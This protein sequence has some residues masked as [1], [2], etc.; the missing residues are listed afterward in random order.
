MLRTLP[1]LKISDEFREMIRDR[2]DIVEIIG[3]TVAL[4]Q[5]G[6]DFVGLCP[7]HEERTPS[8]HVVPSKQFFHCFGCKVGGDV[9][10]FVKL[11]DKVDFVDAV[12]ILADD[13]GVPIPEQESQDPKAPKGFS[14]KL[15]HRTLNEVADF[16]HRQLLQNGQADQARK[17]LESRDIPLEWWK[18][19]QLGYAPSGPD[20]LFA[21]A[22]RQKKWSYNLLTHL[23]L[24]GRKSEG[25][26]FYER[27][28]GRLI[29]PIHD[30]PGNVIGFSARRLPPDTFG[31]KYIN[32]RETDLFHKGRILYNLHRAKEE[33]AKSGYV[34]VCEGQLDA[35]TL[36]MAGMPNVVAA[37]GTAWTPVHSKMMRRH[38]Q[39]LVLALDGDV[40][41][42]T[43][44]GA[45]FP[46]LAAAEID[47]KVV[48]MPAGEDPNSY[49]QKHGVDQLR[50]LFRKAIDFFD[51]Q[52]DRLVQESGGMTEAQK[53]H[54]IDTI[55]G[56]VA[57]LPNPLYRA[58]LIDRL[59]PRLHC[60]RQAME[61]QLGRLLGHAPAA[62][63][64]EPANRKFPR[65]DRFQLTPEEL[66]LQAALSSRQYAEMAALELTP[67]E[68]PNTPP[69]RVLQELLQISLESDV[70]WTGREWNH[71]MNGETGTAIS[72][73]L[74][75]P[76]PGDWARAARDAIFALKR[77]AIEQQVDALNRKMSA[78]PDQIDLILR[79]K[80]KLLDRLVILHKIHEC[81]EE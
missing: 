39:Q 31:G 76:V 37:Q 20:S 25:N 22:V 43:A 67:S 49:F 47:V 24:I 6:Q 62:R 3:K 9:F 27:F 32:T 59:A 28:R 42:Q 14:R 41:G 1:M 64:T 29:F 68:I 65:V 34:I 54:R 26:K 52:V 33:I 35:I 74:M 69:G 36:T 80:R 53:I 78:A 45:I 71:L 8:F 19:F 63:R 57:A 56:F 72:K 23:D 10:E 79:Q 30:E 75:Q 38:T 21:W 13:L 66:L 58:S 7:F 60:S 48:V 61:E 50:A 73:V 5:A 77:G 44:A 40:A 11:R 2:A 17:Y 70:E 16:Y 81:A 51:W 55:L 12:R 46:K 15:Q 18:R 4:K